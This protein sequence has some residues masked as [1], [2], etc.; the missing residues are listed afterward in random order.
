[1]NL[2]Q[3]DERFGHMNVFRYPLARTAQKYGTLLV[4][5]PVER[6]PKQA[7]ELVEQSLVVFTLEMVHAKQDREIAVRDFLYSVLIG[8][9]QEDGAVLKKMHQY[10]LNYFL[11]YHCI[12]I[13]LQ[14]AQES[15]NPE[16]ELRI[17]PEA[18]EAQ[19]QLAK[20]LA[21]GLKGENQSAW[22]LKG[23]HG[24]VVLWPSDGREDGQASLK[25]GL[26]GIQKKI[27]G[28]RLDLAK[29]KIS[30]GVSSICA[31]LPK[32]RTAYEEAWKALKIGLKTNG[33]GS[34]THF[35]ELGLYP[36]FDAD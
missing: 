32:C 33:P 28:C 20:A 8:E 11:K 16:D 26:A 14:N 24:I 6:L 19:D 7:E 15:F 27:G 22:V 1:M 3:L 2:H 25:E 35:Q 18:Q 36:H 23:S 29:W 31:E 12:L 5:G 17:R 9:T 4:A 21:K 10:N 13:F 34:V 30:M